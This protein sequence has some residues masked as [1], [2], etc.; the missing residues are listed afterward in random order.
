MRLVFVL[1]L[2]LLMPAVVPTVAA[3]APQLVADLGVTQELDTYGLYWRNTAPA[4]AAG[5]TFFVHNDGIH[6]FELW[7]TDGTAAGTSMAADVCPGA[8]PGVSRLRPPTLLGVG[9][10]VYFEADDGLTG[11]ELWESDGTPTGTRRVADLRTA[12]GV[13]STPIWLTPLG[14]R[15]LFVADTGGSTCSLFSLVVGDDDPA[16]VAAFPCATYDDA[17]S[18]FT[19]LGAQLVFGAMTSSQGR[20]LWITDGT[21]I[22]TTLLLDVAPGAPSGL[23]SA[24]SEVFRWLRWLATGTRVFFPAADGVHGVELWASDGTAAG[25]SMVVD[26]AAGSAD[27]T[28]SD[29][30][31]L[32]TDLL[33]VATTAATGAEIWRIPI[34]GPPLPE[35]LEVVPG[36]T[37]SGPAFL[38][39][40]SAGAFFAASRSDV[41]REL[42]VT[43]G[44]SAGTRL[45]ADTV[46]GEEGLPFSF[47]AVNG[48]IEADRLFFGGRDHR[49][50]ELWSSD[51]SAAGTSIVADLNPGPDSF[52]DTEVG[53][54]RAMP[55]T[56]PDG[57]HLVFGSE[58]VH[59]REPWLTD[60]A[61]G[62]SLL[63]DV[64]QQ[65]SI[66]SCFPKLCT[67][68]VGDGSRLAF[69]A[70]DWTAGDV[71]IGSRAV[72]WM[73]G[74]AQ[75]HLVRPQNL[76]G[77]WV[78]RWPA[79]G[80]DLAAWAN[81]LLFFPAGI[82]YSNDETWMSDG[83]PAGTRRVRDVAPAVPRDQ[84]VGVVSRFGRAYLAFD[85]YFGGGVSRQSLWVT[86]GTAAGTHEIGPYLTAVDD[87]NA[88]VESF[89]LFSRT[90][91]TVTLWQLD[92]AASAPRA[93]TTLDDAWWSVVA[94]IPLGPG[95]ER[96]LLLVETP[97]YWPREPRRL[98][99][100][101]AG[102]GL[103]LLSN[104]FVPLA[105]E[106]DYEVAFLRPPVALLGNRVL[107][108]AG[109]DEHGAELWMTD[110]T[111]AGTH[112]V[113]DVYPG[114][115]GSHPRWFMVLG[116]ALYFSAY[117]P[118][119]GREVWR[120][121]GSTTE[122]VLDV[123]PGAPSSM[124]SYLTAVEDELYFAASA[125]GAGVELLSWDTRA[126]GSPP[127][128]FDVFAGADS[129]SPTNLTSM[130]GQLYFFA[131]DGVH[132]FEL[133]RLPVGAAMFAD[134]FESGNL[135]RW[136]RALTQ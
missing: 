37:G 2:L 11:V 130:S 136:S 58:P 68:L 24:G 59:G 80:L 57:R 51:G 55:G 114:D 62:I 8:C 101:S 26:L 109:D 79:F 110:G 28:P 19:P 43:D 64:D 49:G 6:G 40:T 95:G 10:R 15:L 97:P 118:G 126:S 38:G 9:S 25:T 129:S 104:D 132:G 99:S 90:G 86:D 70:L 122:L 39:T 3:A 131:N 5:R 76:T 71:T 112:L 91:S 121:D 69:P 66:D 1:S 7:S 17:P 116:S 16:L 47:R 124:P 4:T 35:A 73:D 87:P 14:D 119:H 60:G 85:E 75:A 32:G 13:G 41:G 84:P 33:F 78:L 42:F 34:A 65:S 22:G 127:S 98:W 123:M 128:V 107:F 113:A 103:V 108:V 105:G 115:L 46:P 135:A 120:S 106:W 96:V 45:V 117:E 27:S 52:F 74:T 111:A 133:W 18:D 50:V 21:A 53:W 77:S 134:G 89:L 102:G 48:F 93:L 36:T 72:G 82:D 12:P 63:A 56:L 30:A 88:P 29:L 83:T 61:G 125:P 31:L 67:Q 44:T 92:D 94:E 23:S 54:P 20:E 100:W 81:G